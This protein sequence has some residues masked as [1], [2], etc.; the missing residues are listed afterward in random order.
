M[1]LAQARLGT[2]LQLDEHTNDSGAKGSP[3]VKYVA[4]H[5]VDDTQFWNVSLRVGDGMDDLFDT[6]N[7]I[8]RRGSRCT[9]WTNDE[10]VSRPGHH[11]LM[12]PCFTMLHCVGPM[13]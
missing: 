3:M 8:S 6:S 11:A 13:T 4:E 7:H 1:I 12:V 9:T 2:L 10:A 5:W